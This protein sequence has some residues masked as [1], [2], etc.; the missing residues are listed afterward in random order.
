MKKFLLIDGSNVM[1][2][3]YF[4]TAAM[5]ANLMRNQKGFPTNMVYGF[6]NIYTKIINNGYTHVAVA[7]D[8][9]KKTRRHLMYEDYKAGRQKTPQELLD[10]IPYLHK[11]LDAMNIKHFWSFDYEADD[12]VAS[13]SKKFY[14]DFDEIDVLSNDNDLFQLIRPKVFQVYTEKK[15]QI[16]FNEEML[17]EK[18]GVRPSQIPDFKALIG[19]K[20]DNLPG[21]EGIG[22]VTAA[23]LLSQYETLDGIYEHID[24]IKG[25]TNERLV[26]GKD[27]AFFTKDMATLD[28]TFSF[29]ES[30]DDFAIK[31]P[32]YEK[33]VELY[34]ELDF[35]SFLR[36]IPRN[37]IKKEFKYEIKD[38]P[39]SLEEIIDKENI[40]YLV[41]DVLGEYY[42]TAPQIGFGLTNSKGTFFI[43]Y[44]T[45]IS[46]FDFQ[47]FLGDNSIKKAVYDYKQMYSSLL[48]DDIHLSGV[49]FDLLLGA[50][51]I[52]P[53]L[54]KNGFS[55]M[56][57][58]FGYKE[59]EYDE[60]VYG[61]K[62]REQ[63]PFEDVYASHIAKK[64]FAISLVYDEVMKEIKENGQEWLFSEVE[65]PLSKTLAKME[66]QGLR[67]DPIVLS[68]YHKNLE[69]ELNELEDQIHNLAGHTFNIQ[70][71]KQLGTILFEE[72]GLPYNG[73]KKESGYQTDSSTLETIKNIHPIIELIL[74]YRSVSKLL[75]T[76]VVGV[77]NAIQE[78]RD[79]HIHTIYKQAWTDTGR[80]SSIEPNLQNLPYRDEETKKFRRVFI[81]EDGCYLMSSDYSQ[82]ELRVLAH[83]AKEKHL[84]S[85]FNNGEDIHEATA[86]AVYGKDSVTKEERRSA[87]AVN[88]GIVY[89]ISDFGLSND[90]GI[91]IPEAKAFIKKYH[92]SFPMIEP[93]TQSLIRNAEKDGYVSTMFNR[94]RYIRDIHA[95]N[96]N[97]RNFAMRTAMNAPI[98]GT[99]ADI[100]K[101]A[102]VKLDKAIE[103]SHLHA[104]LILTIHDEVVLNVPIEE[105]EETKKLTESIMDSAVKLDVPLIVDSE[106]GINLYEA[107]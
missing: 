72:M 83:L 22:P 82:I 14:E 31:E 43:P 3:A 76:Y 97:M 67:V 4:A 61:K 84:I 18:K 28:P 53:E 101:I 38:D 21:V 24:E 19:D 92:E 52:S 55:A 71:P 46:S 35:Q 7:F 95:S 94:R 87:K 16:L 13:L 9:G 44:E 104:K 11:F 80:L 36:K 63:L 54:T 93:Y 8:K 51:L 107:K 88:F 47:Y 85:A 99:A 89:G 42:H 6:I 77:E 50:Y 48:K 20:S 34:E 27:T 81:A 10:Q 73:K 58:H 41:L 49:T 5:N 91:S 59:V 57:S 98:Q 62:G 29:I 25:K 90:L 56:A 103:E 32:N 2:R 69:K 45:A 105:I 30:E 96:Y 39:F 65:I 68:E 23:K 79:N 102:M 12:I 33:L 37:T 74:K 64:S 78:K 60:E 100:L 70:S 40:N 15:E 86:K 17:M 106:Y 75:Q 66:Y 1:F 26:S